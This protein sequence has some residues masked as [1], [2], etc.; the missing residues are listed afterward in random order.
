MSPTLASVRQGNKACLDG[1][2]ARISEQEG[3]GEDLVGQEGV[4]YSTMVMEGV[5]SIFKHIFGEHVMSPR[6][7]SII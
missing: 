5:F 3:A 4:N 1:F 7:E 6:W 2:V